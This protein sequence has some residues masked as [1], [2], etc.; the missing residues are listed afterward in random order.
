M[1]VILPSHF[2]HTA[3]A[4]RGFPLLAAS[5]V[6]LA[7]WLSQGLIA[8]VGTGDGRIALLPLSVTAVALALLAGALAWWA[9]NRGAS[10]APLLLLT[11]LFLPWLPGRLPNILLLWTGPI[12]WLLWIATAL[13]MAATVVH[14][15]FRIERPQITAAALALAI[16]AF[17]LW[18]VSPS[19]P[20]GDEPHYLII[21]QSLLS[22]GDLRIEN[23]HR[24][25][26]YRSYING[27]L[28]PDFRV[29]GRNG[30]IYSIHAPG[31]SALVAPAFAVGGY[32][33]VVIFLLVIS[34]LGSALAWHLA[35]LVSGREDAA[36]FGWAAVTLSATWIFHSFTVYPDGPGA[37]LALTGLWAIIRAEHEADSSAE[38]LV[39]WLLHGA[40]LGALPWM[41]T[42]FAA[43]AGLAG[44][45]V[46]LRLPAVRNPAGKAFAFLC[47]PAFSGLAWLA[48]FI[49]IYGTPN[50]SAPYGGEVN[51]LAFIPGGL[52]GLLLDQ[53][54]GLLAYAP[55]LLCAFAGLAGMLARP[56][57]RRYALE[58]LFV[59]VPYLLVVTYVA[60]WWGG[61]SA[62]ARFFAPV[63]LWMAVP[64]A[65]AWKEFPARAARAMAIGSLA[66]TGFASAALVLVGDGRMAFNP[67]PAQ[68]AYALWLEWLNGSLDLG[69]G[70]PAWWRE[71]E[72]A[73]WTGILVWGAAAAAGY[74]SANA[75][76]RH[77]RL[78]GRGPFVTAAAGAFTLIAMAA[79]SVTWLAQGVSGR[80]ATAGQL[81]LLRRVATVPRALGLQLDRPRRISP[82]A[83]AASLRIE[84]P[85][86]NVEGGAGRN[87]RPLFLLP[88]IPAGE[89]RL[90]F[91][92]RST[93]GW[94]MIGIGRD[95][96]ALRTQPVA[97]DSQPM[98]VTFPVDVRALIVRADEDARQSVRS[99]VLE[100]LRILTPRERLA[101]PFARR[102]VRYA[103]ATV[104]FTDDRSFPEPEAFWVGGARTSTV[105]LQPDQSRATETLLVR[106]GAAENEVMIET[107]SWRDGARLG[108]GEERRIEVPLDQARGATVLKFTT[109]AGFRPSAADP[110]SRDDR[111]LGVWVKVLD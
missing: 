93:A 42:R 29:R 83:A 94:L 16:G 43:I 87:D 8:F 95:Q 20:G 106:N 107:G 101:A 5:L 25:R 74:F 49:K 31:V 14:Y 30:E 7:A 80:A 75:L 69:R 48:Y 4:W 104:F 100:P 92:L 68:G 70:L 44:A 39:P 46:L 47:V 89:Y 38:S 57:L 78:T 86:S 84:P 11:F 18:Q 12:V 28:A 6:S 81:D 21:T 22:D 102:A 96:F 59:V 24:Q 34:A 61:A 62:P 67:R 33:G 36:W 17:S 111:F 52:A 82:Q 55:V 50:P 15:R 40:A 60:M 58:I 103:T 91:P 76:A 13:C 53:R 2:F 77:P 27:D 45:L 63:L 9:I 54:F 56:R 79:L 72:S 23:N 108:P 51:S 109:S 71:D 19:V 65:I 10:A 90:S 32:R 3:R 85:F 64:A 97:A 98:T 35:W 26:D 105:V 41:H 1:H 73:L 88:S 37:V 66:V 99:F 110:A